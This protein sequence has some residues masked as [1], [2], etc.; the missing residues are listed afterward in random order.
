MPVA[1]PAS[2]AVVAMPQHGV[3]KD[4]HQGPAPID[5]LRHY[6]ETG[7]NGQDWE[8]RLGSGNQAGSAQKTG[9]FCGEA[10][11]TDRK[12]TFRPS[13]KAASFLK[14]ELSRFERWWIAP[15]RRVRLPPTSKR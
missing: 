1:D 3:Q 11:P 8:G 4:T 6:G 10:D 5:S 9:M 15:G 2:L 7:R 12:A 14:V 13:R